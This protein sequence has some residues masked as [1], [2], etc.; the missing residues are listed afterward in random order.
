VTTELA[1]LVVAGAVTYDWSVRDGEGYKVSKFERL[2][3][4]IAIRDN[5]SP[6]SRIGGWRVIFIEDARST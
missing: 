4:P 6:A 2:L 1:A 5:P 3:M